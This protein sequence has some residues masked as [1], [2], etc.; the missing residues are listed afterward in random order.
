MDAEL[1]RYLPAMLPLA[2]QK[3][4]YTVRINDG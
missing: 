3:M 2:Y 1:L 4:I